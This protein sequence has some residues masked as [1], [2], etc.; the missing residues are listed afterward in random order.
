MVNYISQFLPHIA[1]ITAPLTDL[2]RNAEFV[3]TPTHDT[4]FQNTRRLADDNEVIR[5]INHESGV[6]IWVITDA[7]DRGVG[8]WVA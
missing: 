2:T 1:R 5:P 8:V 7:S 4:A 3:R 6:P